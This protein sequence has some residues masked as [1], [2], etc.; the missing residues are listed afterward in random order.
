MGRK[1]T[2]LEKRIAI[3]LMEGLSNKS[4]SS[5]LGISYQV[6]KNYMHH[7]FDKTGMDNRVALAL[8]LAKYPEKL[9]ID[10]A[11]SKE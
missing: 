11:S 10:G 5:D 8:H 6:V 4:I 3:K 2:G 7:I 1:L 9:I